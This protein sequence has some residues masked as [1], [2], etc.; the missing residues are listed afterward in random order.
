MTRMTGLCVVV[1]MMGTMFLTIGCGSKKSDTPKEAVAN[2][3]KAIESGD[4]DLFLA[5][6]EVGD[7]K[8][9]VALFEFMSETYAFEKKIEDEYG[10]GKLGDS[11]EKSI[12]S[13]EVESKVKIEEKGDTATATWPGR[14]V[15]MQLVKKDG[16]WKVDL[17]QITPK[18]ENSELAIRNYTI[19]AE[20]TKKASKKIGKKGYTAE[21]I[22]T[23]LNKEVMAAMVSDAMKNVKPQPK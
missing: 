17:S 7:E 1:L 22:L 12:T 19:M 20:T 2:H 9:A 10:E 5:S 6:A 15:P 18:G 4:K 8:V 3:A 23:E 16:C 11:E 21:K 13:E 14:T